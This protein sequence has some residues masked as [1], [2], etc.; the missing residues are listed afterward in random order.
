MRKTFLSQISSVCE[1]QIKMASVP[2]SL[3][4]RVPTYHANSILLSP[5][6]S[7]FILSSLLLFL[8]FSPSHDRFPLLSPLPSSFSHSVPYVFPLFIPV[9]LSG[10][11]PSLPSLSLSLTSHSIISSFNLFLSLPSTL[12]SSPTLYFNPFPPLSPNRDL[13]T[14][15]LLLFTG[16]NFSRFLKYWI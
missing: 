8:P 14:L 11:A 4:W 5:L 12:F 13:L 1:A 2:G 3:C 7:S 15:V 9:Q 10:F 16:T 6:P